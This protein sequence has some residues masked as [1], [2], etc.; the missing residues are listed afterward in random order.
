VRTKKKF[1]SYGIYIGPHTFFWIY[2]PPVLHPKPA[3][4]AVVE[5][6]APPPPLADCP[7]SKDLLKY[8][9]RIHST[10]S[11]AVD[12]RPVAIFQDLLEEMDD[13]RN[14]PKP[15][16]GVP[17]ICLERAMDNVRAL[18]QCIV[19]EQKEAEKNNT[20]KAQLD[21][22]CAELEARL[23]RMA[24]ER[25]AASKVP[26]AASSH[27]AVQCDLQAPAVCE[28]VQ[29]LS[30]LESLLPPL[31][32]EQSLRTNGED[33]K[34]Y[35]RRPR[36]ALCL[37]DVMEHFRRQDRSDGVFPLLERLVACFSTENDEVEFLGNVLQTVG[38]SAAKTQDAV[39]SRQA[40]FDMLRL[41]KKLPSFE[42]CFIALSTG[43]KTVTVEK[44]IEAPRPTTHTIATQT[45]KIAPE[46]PSVPS[47]V[48]V[49]KPPVKTKE[50]GIQA[51]LKPPVKAAA[52]QTPSVAV[53][54]QADACCATD[55]FLLNQYL[56]LQEGDGGN[57]RNN[58]RAPLRR[59]S[60]VQV[61][62]SNH[63][64]SMV[65]STREAGAAVTLLR[66][67]SSIPSK[68]Q[69]HADFVLSGG[70]VAPSL[71]SSS[72]GHPL[73]GGSTR[74]PSSALMHPHHTA[75]PRDWDTVYQEVEQ[76][77]SEEEEDDGEEASGGTNGII[78]AVVPTSETRPP[79]VAA[80]QASTA[81]ILK[82]AFGTAEDGDSLPLSQ[83]QKTSEQSNRAMSDFYSK[84]RAGS[85]GGKRTPSAGD[86][87]PSSAMERLGNGNL[88]Q[89]SVEVAQLHQQ[90]LTLRDQP[91]MTPVAIRQQ[92]ILSVVEGDQTTQHRFSK[93]AAIETTTIPDGTTAVRRP[94]VRQLIRDVCGS[95][96]V[97]STNISKVRPEQQ[98]QGLL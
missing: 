42:D 74:R 63:E 53:R 5:V 86:K 71:S 27:A 72:S 39:R 89:R 47:A 18:L 68:M 22:K 32:Q 77:H 28:H 33:G 73:G 37:S 11:K 19:A 38:S 94:S 84:L 36:I 92:Q 43:P 7:I 78:A 69:S 87:R 35:E 70:T 65:S 29:A 80:R 49:V 66:R 59:S 58:K 3:P 40:Y 23:S 55:P 6:V 96:G 25:A 76:V 41:A 20:A 1:F 67:S 2:I 88:R 91:S 52:T 62:G 21:G 13:W 34:S 26:V 64:L 50:S 44:V 10:L 17:N 16:E 95:R 31:E 85:A 24:E 45:P 46:V 9:D 61:F 51:T 97:L 90:I 15:A 48:T 93:D 54:T 60:I 83:H 30:G 14:V 82:L 81:K 57:D 4:P 98:Q 8:L 56:G 75:P 79:V 12:K